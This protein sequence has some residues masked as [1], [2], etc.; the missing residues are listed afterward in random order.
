[1]PFVR[2]DRAV[3]KDEFEVLRQ[4]L[5]LVG[6]VLKVE[7]KAFADLEPHTERVERGDVR[8]RLDGIS[9]S[10]DRQP[11]RANRRCVHSPAP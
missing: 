5:R 6:A 8:K 7:V 11:A 9:P 10:P 4:F 1:M 2:V 3:R